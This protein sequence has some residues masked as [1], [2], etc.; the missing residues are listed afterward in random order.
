LD[1]LILVLLFVV[2]L[3][4]KHPLDT[5]VFLTN[6]MVRSPGHFPKRA[7]NGASM[8]RKGS[9]NVI[10]FLFGFEADADI[11]IIADHKL[12]R[13]LLVENRIAVAALEVAS[14]LNGSE[15]CMVPSFRSMEAGKSSTDHSAKVDIEVGKSQAGVVATSAAKRFIMDRKQCL[16]FECFSIFYP[17]K[18]QS[19]VNIEATNLP[20]SKQASYV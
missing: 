13:P 4:F 12:L 10:P 15:L 1:F 2:A 16:V 11:N 19:L 3:R 18:F 5:K 7:H 17:N 8:D 20:P 14:L 6:A 9:E